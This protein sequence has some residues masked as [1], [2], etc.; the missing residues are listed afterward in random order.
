MVV[1]ITK[2]WSILNLLLGSLTLVMGYK[3]H[4]CDDYSSVDFIWF[5]FFQDSLIDKPHDLKNGFVSFKGYHGSRKNTFFQLSYQRLQ[6]QKMLHKNHD[7][8]RYILSLKKWVDWIRIRRE[9]MSQ[10]QKS[11]F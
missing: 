3:L 4:L 9:K 6:R 7:S 5:Y 1:K 10:P 8:Y 11:T 2:Y